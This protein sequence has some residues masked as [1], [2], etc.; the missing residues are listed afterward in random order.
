MRYNMQLENF[1][2]NIIQELSN[3]NTDYITLYK[4][5]NNLKIQQIF[6]TLHFNL[7]SELKSL[8]LRLP[9]KEETG[10]YHAA[11]SRS[12]LDVFEKIERV[13]KNL[14]NTSFQFD[15][16]NYINSIISKCKTFV[17]QYKGS[18]IP[19]NTEKIEIYY[20]IPI[21]KF[22]NL[23]VLEKKNK[24][25]Y[26]LQMIGNGSYANVYKY[27]D[28][29]YDE[30]FVLKR[31]KKDRNPKDVIRFKQEFDLMKSNQHPNIVRVYKFFDDNT[32]TMDYC[33][34]PLKQFI[35]R[36][37]SK[38]T[39]E[40]RIQLINQLL[41]VVAFL[42]DRGI[43]HRDLSYNNILIDNKYSNLFLKISD[44]GLTKDEN[45]KIT[46]DDSSIKGTY[47]DPCLDK[48]ENYSAQ[49]DIY[50]I[51]MMINYIYFGKQSV[52]NND[53][54]IDKIIAKCIENKLDKRYKNINQI[55]FN[56]KTFS[57][58]D[59]NLD[60]QKIKSNIINELI[61]YSA[62][63]LPNICKSLGL[64]EGTIEEAFKSKRNYVYNRLIYLSIEDTLN[65]IE[66]INNNMGIK[67]NTN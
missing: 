52:S 60:I 8:N 17:K 21:F 58:H 18:I 15:I 62:N 3:I 22:K 46:S 19:P 42:H 54:I 48:F 31:L 56:I 38:L 30:F 47:I 55:I 64:K 14:D 26:E 53:T 29:D 16:D 40:S 10:Y 59:E 35:D 13:K 4:D 27:K 44:F 66:K 61:N 57:M 25:R 43:Y 28:E 7:N 2:E 6:S 11:E 24:S 51:G 23:N 33:G 39:K 65:V 5:I 50:A 32:Y 49:N 1:F 36:N 34:Y 63:N 37:N 12:L 9:T 41:E 67:I 45:N 20:T